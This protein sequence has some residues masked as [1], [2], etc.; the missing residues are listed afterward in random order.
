MQGWLSHLANAGLRDYAHFGKPSPPNVQYILPMYPGNTPNSCKSP[1]D[2]RHLGCILPRVQ[3]ARD[4]V[5]D[6]AAPAV[7]GPRQWRQGGQP[8]AG[9]DERPHLAGVCS[10]L[11]SLRRLS[12]GCDAHGDPQVGAGALQVRRRECSNRPPQPHCHVA[13]DADRCRLSGRGC[14]ARTRPSRSSTQK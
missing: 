12:C 5:V 13:S 11:P 1:R 4:A 9:D 7:H 2:C 8:L 3:A 10:R 14:A 6:R